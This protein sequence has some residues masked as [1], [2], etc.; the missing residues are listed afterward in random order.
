MICEN[1]NIEFTGNYCNNCGQKKVENRLNLREISNN[2]ISSLFNYESGFLKTIFFLI[3]KPK[4]II[5][6]YFNGK[7]KNYFNPINLLFIIIAIKAF[8]EINFLYEY[9]LNSSETNELYYKITHNDYFK[10]VQVI[11]LIPILSFLSYLFFKKYKYNFTEHILTNIF[12]ITLGSIFVTIGYLVH[13]LLNNKVGFSILIIDLIFFAWIYANLFDKNR[14]LSFFKA[15]IIMA[16]GY[17]IL[18]LPLVLITKY[19]Y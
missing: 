3:V 14:I 10:T 15:V 18:L 17:F 7:R 16:L 2:L 13:I 9:N 5:L 4:T 12:A 11:C 1:C 8:I 19:F 6:D